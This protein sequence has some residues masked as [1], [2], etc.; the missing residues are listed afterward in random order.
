MRLFHKRHIRLLTKTRVTE[1][2][3]NEVL[4][5]VRT[6]CIAFTLCAQATR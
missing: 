5:S 3:P 4:L 2:R 1:V 6:G